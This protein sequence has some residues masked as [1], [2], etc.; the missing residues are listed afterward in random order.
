[1]A[2]TKLPGP[3][4]KSLFSVALEA[5][6]TRNSPMEMHSAAHSIPLVLHNAIVEQYSTVV[7]DKLNCLCLELLATAIDK[8]FREVN[9]I[10]F[11]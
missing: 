8:I 4:L 10:Y 9:K 3:N 5:E 1:M 2:S 11:N 7:T 6:T